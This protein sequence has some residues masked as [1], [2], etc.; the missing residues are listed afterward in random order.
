MNF[1]QKMASVRAVSG[2]TAD[3]FKKL[4]ENARE[5]G[6]TTT[7]TATQVADLQLVYSRLGFSANDILAI[8]SATLSLATATGED[9]AK[10][11]DVAGSTLRGF[12]LEAKEMQRVVDVMARSFNSSALRLD[13]FANSMKMVAPIAKEAGVSLEETSAMLGVLA[14][15]G[16]RGTMA[17]TALRRIFTEIARDGG[18]VQERLAQLSERGITVADAFDEVGRTAMTALTI[19]SNSQEGIDTLTEKLENSQGAAAEAAAIMRDTL[20]GDVKIAQSAFQEFLI[21]LGEG[22]APVARVVVQFFTMIAQNLKSFFTVIKNVGIPAIVAL[23]A[24][25]KIYFSWK[26]KSTAVTIASTAAYSAETLAIRSQIL[27]MQKASTFGKLF[28]VVKALITGN[29]KMATIAWRAFTAALKANPFGIILTVVATVIGLFTLF[30]KKTDES[31]K[32]YSDFTAE[33]SKEQSQ[34]D[35]L[36]KSALAAAAGTQERA[37]AIKILNEKY[38]EYLPCLLTEKSTNEEIK[39]ALEGVNDA[40]EKNLKLKARQTALEGAY[41]DLAKEELRL[42]DKLKDNYDL[43]MSDADARKFMT[44]WKEFT[45][46]VKNGQEIAYYDV[47]K[48]LE[49]TKDLGDLYSRMNDYIAFYQKHKAKLKEIDIWYGNSADKQTQKQATNTEKQV[50]LEKKKLERI[51]QLREK[52]GKFLSADI[53]EKSTNKDIDEAEKKAEEAQKKALEKAEETRKKLKETTKAAIEKN[54][55][56]IAAMSRD[57]ATR[58]I[59]AEIDAM[60]EGI[61]KKLA[62][63]DETTRKE[64]E[65]YELNYQK[66]IDEI[67][68]L[69]EQLKDNGLGNSSE[70]KQLEEQ[71]NT[72]TDTNELYRTQI[73]QENAKKR[74][75][76]IEKASSEELEAVELTSEHIDAVQTELTNRILENQRK[77]QEEFEKTQKKALHDAQINYETQKAI[78]NTTAASES[79]RSKKLIENEINLRKEKVKTFEAELKMLIEIGAIDNERYQEIL[80]NLAKIRQEITNFEEGNVDENGEP[81]NFWDKMFNMSEEDVAKIK[82][83]AIELAKQ[84]G[85]SIIEAQQAANQR[86]LA[87]AKKAIDSEYKIH[88]KMLDDKRDKGLISEKKYQEEL[89]KLEAEKAKKE[90]EAERAAFEKDKEIRKRQALMDMAIGIVKIWSQA[91]IN[92]VVGAVMSAALVATTAIQIAAINREKYAKGGLIDSNKMAVVK[93][94]SH[95]QGG[96]QIYIDGKHIGEIEGDELLAIVNKHDTRRLSAL[97]KLNSVHG[98]KFAEGGVINPIPA[99]AVFTNSNDVYF[100]HMLRLHEDTKQMIEAINNRIDSI[101]VVVVESDITSIQKNVK[102]VQVKSSF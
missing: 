62:K 90:E 67:N 49:V 96:H 85:S 51:K 5:L 13:H 56:E 58:I 65:K 9:L 86:R 25:T 92:A 55:E 60:D 28:A 1:E 15:R 64:L 59:N 29:I 89:E 17:G 30:R 100:E 88:M 38:G 4:S 57:F 102:K 18:E 70:Y 78:I 32:A 31:K 27:A 21:W 16:I 97:S 52:Y 47:A 75:E 36:K 54:S 37:D 50:E 44:V 71:K 79:E 99:P 93:G 22:L 2:A 41:G 69:Q 43:N 3:E 19:L 73:T 98:K 45:D 48:K 26:A 7:H 10:S 95:T 68:K 80:A 42:L 8:T 53:T 72:L 74:T 34:L 11:A 83:Q 81:Q 6:E 35:A 63:Q 14:N 66:K 24:A 82:Q 61:N 40:I 77:Q 101:Q 39:T 87:S 94:R 46:A 91:G 33:L 20:T 12:G 84:I 23:Y 76:I